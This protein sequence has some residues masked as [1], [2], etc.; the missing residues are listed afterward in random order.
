MSRDQFSNFALAAATVLLMQACVDEPAPTEVA[1]G[2]VLTTSVTPT[3]QVGRHLVLF[4]AEKVPAEFG[5][6]V[7]R[8]GGSVE[9]SLDHIGVAAVTG[10]TESAAADLAAEVGIQHVEPDPILAM[11]DQG[12]EAADAPDEPAASEAL[13]TADAMASPASAQF[14]PRQWNLRAVSAPQA[15]A[16]GHFGSRD[17][18]VAILDTG[19]D[20]LHPDLVGLV[21]LERS[22]SLVPEEDAVV[23]ALFPGRLPFSDLFWHGTAVSSV[24]ASNARILAGVTRDVTLIAVKIWNRSF[25]GPVSRL[26]AGIVYAADQSADVINVSGGYD[27]DKNENPGMVAAFERAANYAFRKGALLVSASFNDAAD[28]DHNGDS[29]RFPCEAAHTIC[30]S[31][32][33]PTTGVGVNGPWTDVDA[34]ALNAQGPYSGFG[35]SAIGVAAP[36]GSGEGG[37]FR[38]FWASCTTT[39]TET[40][41]PPACRVPRCR[42]GGD[43]FGQCVAQGR[44]TSFAAPTVAGLAALLVAQLGHGNPALIRA[45]I[46]QTADD[47]GEPGTDPYYGKGRINIARALGLIE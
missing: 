33:G 7:A 38:R 25:R 31:A 24:V 42:Q 8:L 15:W 22:R 11:V 13:A 2:S 43:L 28:L 34:R 46:L 29:V 44:G 27:R 40:T 12:A 3:A 5:E 16:A 30:A 26:L 6:R 17:V 23:E 14:Y 9:A 18:V 36:G 37:Q 45:R 10:L 19:I 39:W 32:T 41:E 1:G 4:A 35:R 20:Y 21:D 47:R